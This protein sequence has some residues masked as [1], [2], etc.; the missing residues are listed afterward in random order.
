MENQNEQNVRQAELNR[1]NQQPHPQPTSSTDSVPQVPETSY[2][3]RTTNP[4]QTSQTNST[5]GAHQEQTN[6]TD[7]EVPPHVAKARQFQQSLKEYNKSNTDIQHAEFYNYVDQ[8]Y[9]QHGYL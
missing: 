8:D 4:Q 2:D 1:H 5:E 3:I 9:E 6:T 7:T